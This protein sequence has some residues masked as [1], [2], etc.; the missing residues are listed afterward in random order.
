MTLVSDVKYRFCKAI[1]LETTE[2]YKWVTII[3]IVDDFQLH[4]QREWK[5]ISLLMVIYFYCK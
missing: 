3:E 5:R 1:A 2:C 4:L